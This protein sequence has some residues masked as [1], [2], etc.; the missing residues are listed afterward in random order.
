MS[1]SQGRL[2]QASERGGEGAVRTL[3]QAHPLY[4]SLWNSDRF[5]QGSLQNI[6]GKFILFLGVFSEMKQLA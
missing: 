6:T 2:L 1:P 5:P 3:P 4:S